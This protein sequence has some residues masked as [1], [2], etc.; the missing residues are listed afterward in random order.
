MLADYHIIRELT[1]TQS[2]CL[3]LAQ[4]G[5]TG[6]KVVLKRLLP[7]ALEED[8][9][10]L[11][12][13]QQ[14]FRRECNIHLYLK[15]D[16]IVEA[17]D[18]FEHE[19]QPYLVTTYKPY[20][21]LKELLQRKV[22]FSPLEALNIVQQL[23]QALHYIHD[24]GIIHRDIH[25]ENIMVTEENRICLID[26]GCARKVFA[27]S[28]TQD[29]LL[30]GEIQVQGTFYYMSP[31]QFL[32]QSELDFRADVFSVGVI[33]YQLL[34]GHLPFE[35]EA[36]SE[37]MHNLL[38]EAK[39][40][41]PL[42]SQN[43]YVPPA[44]EEVV[45]QT[46]RK[47]PDYRT[48]TARK[49]ALEIEALLTHA[50]LYYG[51]A[52][53]HLEVGKSRENAQAYLIHALQQDP[54]YVPALELLGQLFMQQKNWEQA[55]R[56]YRRLLDLNPRHGEARFQM[57]HIEQ[58]EGYDSCA[59]KAF[60]RALENAPERK[61]VRLALVESLL[62][63]ARYP[64]ALPHLQQLMA[65]GPPFSQV[66]ELAGQVYKMLGYREAALGCYE[67]A[68]QCQADQPA[69]LTELAALQHELGRYL[70]AALTY[71]RLLTFDQ[72]P[73]LRHNLAN[74]YYQTGE[75]GECRKLLEQ[76]IADEGK[77]HGSDWEMSYSLLG[78]VYSR[79]SQHED[80][81]EMYKHALMCN[82]ENLENYLF[83][84][85]AY[86]EKLQLEDALN[87]LKYVSERPCGQQEAMV[88]FLIARAYYEQGKEN[89]TIQ[90]LEQCLS[91]HQTLTAAMQHQAS[92][93]LDLL[94]ER[95]KN[96]LRKQRLARFR[97]KEST[98]VR[99]YSRETSMNL[100]NLPPTSGEKKR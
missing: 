33:L 76:L 89:E 9:L 20:P 14:R 3:W 19:N 16:S 73:Q 10:S 59:V 30:R 96:R 22:S 52:R 70:E 75:I 84:A 42:R 11:H 58:A 55:R 8:G 92:Q 25:P 98:T 4:H 87:T 38:D 51:E 18:Y 97:R 56:C 17:L 94:Y 67:K 21:T 80:A 26:F 43:P 13:R 6:Q 1:R 83:L 100:L 39:D 61:E 63:V 53:W 69:V 31:E 37:T 66:Y 85:A 28:V 93:D 74:V 72:S 12:E 65:Q 95:Q 35:G 48:P 50:T 27:P 46:L 78:F 88:Y 71:Q 2:C 44:L 15:H 29:T 49:L 5:S 91:C 34:T 64:D 41:H 68:L 79:L 60:E 77:P 90:A 47:D 24:Q 99:D 7:H 45:F 36:L 86:R 54:E 40:P 82:P 57:G 81:I 32:G 62:R 23:C